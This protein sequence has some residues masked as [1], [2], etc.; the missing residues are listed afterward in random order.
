MSALWQRWTTKCQAIAPALVLFAIMLAHALLETARDALFLARLGP[1]YL[2][3]A[4]VAIAIAALVTVG[5]VRRRFGRGDSRRTL[6]VLLVAASIG[7]GILGALLCIPS[8]VFVLYVWTGVVATLVVPSFWV[9]LDRGTVVVDAKR[10]FAVVAA[11]GSIGALVGSGLAAALG[12][13]VI[14]EVLVGL[15]AVS[16]V[17]A[18]VVV[19]KLAPAPMD[20]HRAQV[21]RHEARAKKRAKRTTRYVYLLLALGVT[22][23]IAVTLGDLMFKRTL[24]ERLPAEELATWFG[25]I[26]TAL[27]VIGLVVQIAVTPRLLERLGVGGALTVLPMV[28]LATALGFLVTGAAIAVIAL[29][30]GDG[31]LRHSVHRVA[32]EIL[33]LPIAHEH[34]DAV[35]PIVDMVGQRGGQLLAALLAFVVASNARGTWQLGAMAAIAV[36][37]W[38]VVIALTRTSYVQLFRDT[39]AAGE[40]ARQSHVPTLDGSAIAM[41]TSSLS[42]PDENEALAALDLL[43]LRGGAIPTLVLYHPST[44]V[45]RR[46]LGAIRDHVRPDVARVL[47]HLATHKDPQIR[48]AALAASARAGCSTCLAAALDD[49]A[50][51]VR[52]AAAVGLVFNADHDVALGEAAMAKLV[53]GSIEE[54]SA[55]VRA[56]GRVPG[57]AFKPVLDYLGRGRETDVIREVLAVWINA[58]ALA[59]VD[60]LI[61]LLDEPLCRS[62]ARRVFAA[63]QSLLP[64]LIA[65]LDDPRT[66]LGVRR[67]LPRT[68][69]RYC[70][71]AAAAA[72]VERLVREPDG[73]TEF[74]I[75]RAL[76]RMRTDQPKLAIATDP[77]HAYARRAIDDAQ[78]YTMLGDRLRAERSV[79]SATKDLLADLTSEKRRHAIE[80]AF[81]ALDILHP[82]ADMHSVHDAITSIDD[83]RLGAAHEILDGLIDSDLRIPLVAVLAARDQPIG[84]PV[85]TYEE[86]LTALL[87]DPSETLRCVTAHHVGERRLVS[88]RAELARLRPV[89]RS[90]LVSTAFEQAIEVLDA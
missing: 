28:V 48:A 32:S 27:N 78:R 6:A 36:V 84:A 10:T 88:L 59:D 31:G 41:L 42:S 71:P 9:M 66:P 13:F 87:V 1:G 12:R 50:P 74:K 67:H 43:V 54:R 49:A 5:L 24:A 82:R 75:L 69:S 58:P 21:V 83:D 70:T 86:L 33:F 25:A 63:T 64:R 80:R 16:L 7:T 35:K 56:I 61:Q 8:I 55:I 18:A 4:Y 90:P 39:L 29:R 85:M 76:G 46:A 79:T 72:L 17:L 44:T 19:W 45:V 89:A 26:Y 65:A 53:A 11:G 73:T 51:D 77:V 40:I 20:R 3:S 47:S 23:T 15:S 52:A 34:R 38:L 14:P 57:S 30:L 2:A 62:D 37:A 60:R 68:I 81:R 22:S